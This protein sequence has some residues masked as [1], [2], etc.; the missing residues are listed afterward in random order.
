VRKLKTELAMRG[1]HPLSLEEAIDL[2]EGSAR[3]SVTASGR[4]DDADLSRVPASKKKDGN[5][6]TGRSQ[7]TMMSLRSV[8]STTRSSPIRA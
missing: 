6:P 3:A 7:A 8:P 2:I 1:S 4:E 5:D